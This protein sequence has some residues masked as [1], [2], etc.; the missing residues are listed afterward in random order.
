MLGTASPTRAWLLVEE[1]GPWGAGGVPESR[2]GPEVTESLRR[3]A[4]GLSARLLLV[5]R[6]GQARG[7]DGRRTLFLVTCARGR[8]R[9]LVRTCAAADVAAAAADEDGW[10]ER[11]GNLFLV[12]T[13]G[14]KDWCC[15]LRGRPVAQALAALAPEDVWECSHLG[16]DR[17]AASVLTLPTGWTYGRVDADDAAELVA[18]TA[19]GRVLPALARGRCSEAMVAQAA[20]VHARLALG[21]DDV[22]ALRPVAAR[23]DEGDEALWHVDLADAPGGGTLRVSVR[24]TAGSE[25]ALLT[26]G[27]A[28]EQRPPAWD[29][30][31][32]VAREL[33]TG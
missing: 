16:G 24:R 21:V 30:V 20:D 26:C 32:V 23:R 2:L 17:F 22:T 12:C 7:D 31:D 5:R 13:H 25:A 8:E 18:A 1:P 4:S 29:L 3:T 27:A 9:V 19:A 14:R 33:P 6:P 28:Q 15:A 10:S 11:P